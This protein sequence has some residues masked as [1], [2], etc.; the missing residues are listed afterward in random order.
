MLQI[1]N[2]PYGWG[3]RKNNDQQMLVRFGSRAAGIR[4]NKSITQEQLAEKTGL[5]RMT[6]AFI[7]SGRRWPR[8]GTLSRLAKGLGVKI[9]D[10]FKGL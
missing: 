4:I 7:E 10:L 3:M 9:E 2:A 1:V 8:I 6:I 5:D